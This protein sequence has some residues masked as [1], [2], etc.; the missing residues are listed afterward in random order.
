M[1]SHETIRSREGLDGC[2]PT[3]RTELIDF[4]ELS[5]FPQVKHHFSSVI[6]DFDG[7]LAD[8]LWVWDDIDERFC[9]LYG[10]II[11][12]DYHEKI[13]AMTFEETARYYIDELGMDMTVDEIVYH[14]NE[15]AYDRYAHDVELFPGAAEYLD[16]LKK[17][18][19]AMGIATSLSWPLL[20][21]TMV[22]SGIEGYFDDIAFC[23][24]CSS[25]QK[26]DV[27]LLAAERIG[28]RPE[29]CLVFEDL[30]VGVTNARSV[31][32]TACRVV[33]RRRYAA[34]SPADEAGDF[35]IEDFVQLVGDA[36]AA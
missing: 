26:P 6:F 27:F 32:M 20:E 28:A 21:A 14:F 12:D 16:L 8:S 18:G 7:T 11:P 2:A 33:D 13:D 36:G 24:E 23:D 15:L 9:E 35:W 17:R 30:P 25:K 5:R 34:P 31:G 1:L 29:D 3:Q 10:L 19:V 22:S 4:P